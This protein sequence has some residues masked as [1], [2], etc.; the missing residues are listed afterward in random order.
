MK[1]DTTAGFTV[2]PA[3]IDQAKTEKDK[4]EQDIANAQRKLGL[5][6]QFLRLAA[7][8]VDESEPE[9]PENTE[10]SEQHNDLK[11]SNIMGWI[12]RI[13]NESPRPVPKA[14][15][16]IRLTSI[17]VPE[18]RLGN[19]F[20]VAIDRLK[21]NGRISVLPDGRVWKAPP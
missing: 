3:L 15:M 8:Y 21:K 17:G 9:E 4:L 11:P 16:K 6:N 14:E 7:A 5:V 1:T 19:Y 12:A 13:A 2:T 20:Y 18:N 10:E